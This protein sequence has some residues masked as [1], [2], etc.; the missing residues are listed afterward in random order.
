MARK[1]SPKTKIKRSIAKATG[2]PTTRSGRKNKAMRMATG[3]GCL[4]RLA[5][6]MVILGM[7]IFLC[8]CSSAPST[9]VEY[10]VAGNSQKY[11]R[12]FQEC[13]AYRVIVPHETDAD[14]LREVFKVVTHNDGYYLHTMW[15]YRNQEEV[16]RQVWTVASLEEFEK[17][18]EIEIVYAAVQKDKAAVFKEGFEEAEFE[19][20]NS[21]ASQNGLGGTRIWVKGT[22]EHTELL[23]LDDEEIENLGVIMGYLQTEDGNEWMVSMHI[24]PIV[25]PENHFENFVGRQVIMRGVYDGYS[26]VAQMPVFTLDQI[27]DEQTEET[28]YGMATFTGA[29]E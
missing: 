11:V 26:A 27:M 20:Y 24:A 10:K 15:V 12:D 5:M 18:G 7:A 21:N 1:M 25:V 3:G 6:M 8:S 29:M 9:D 22:L 16:D 23:M 13:I 28:V 17:G 4:L 14:K 19:K 2:I